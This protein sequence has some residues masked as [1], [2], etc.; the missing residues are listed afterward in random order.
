[1]NFF[2]QALKLSFSSLKMVDLLSHLILFRSF[3]K[4]RIT[5]KRSSL[6]L[7]EAIVVVGGCGGGG[8]LSGG[9]G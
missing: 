8:G 4:L 3:E 5:L 6:L 9:G 2:P 1:M 7:L